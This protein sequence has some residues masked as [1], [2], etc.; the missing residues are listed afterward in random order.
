MR[1]LI[2]A[3]GKPALSYAKDGIAEY[4]KRL[5]RYS[6]VTMELVKAGGS[7]EVSQ[8]L[9]EKSEGMYRI[10]M[11]ER[12][13]RLTT[14]ELYKRFDALEHRGDVKC[15]AFLIGASDGHTPELRKKADMVLSLSAL[16]LQHE[17]A[18]VVLLEQLYRLA[19]MKA[20]SP[21]HRE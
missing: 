6:Q 2:L 1:L 13:E 8:R 4:L 5:G 10:A 14:A 12:G 18:L 17:L 15:V 11:D 16:T 21:Y 3:A 7:E 9:L 20:G 19:S